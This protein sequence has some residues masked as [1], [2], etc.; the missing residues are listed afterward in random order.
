MSSSLAAVRARNAAVSLAG[1]SAVVVGGTSGIGRG[2][3]VRLAEANASVTIV[4]R[5]EKRAAEVLADLARVGGGGKHA[6]VRV[7]DGSLLAN[8]KSFSESYLRE[9]KT[10]DVLVLTQGI[11]TLQGRTETSEGL[12][13]K[14]ATHF[15]GRMGFVAD[16]LPAL[17]ASAEADPAFTP[18]VLSVLAAGV[19]PPY[20]HYA[21]DF[22][23]KTHYSL[24]NAADACCMYNDVAADSLA[25]ENPSIAFI[26]ASPGFVDTNIASGL[27][28]PLRWLLALTRP[29]ARSIAE[30][31]EFMSEPLLR[32]LPPREARRPGDNFILISQNAEAVKPTSAHEEAR[33]TVWAKTKEVLGRHGV[34]L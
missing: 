21:D 24:K 29:F 11:G 26:H 34:A 19:H 8:T 5:D 10:L 4:G 18:R 32:P 15:F 20:M 12:D 17:R 28:A 31:G 9:H 27:V 23:L 22:E 30:C 13:V 6:F 25:R 2:I 33:E 14:M 3:A 7:A 1:R 16:L